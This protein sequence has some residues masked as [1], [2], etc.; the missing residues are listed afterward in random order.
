MR[1]ETKLA[2]WAQEKPE[3]NEGESVVKLK[4][5]KLIAWI[6][7]NDTDKPGVGAVFG[8]QIKQAKKEAAKRGLKLTEGLLIEASEHNAAKKA[9]K[10]LLRKLE[11]AAGDEHKD[12]LPEIRGLQNTAEKFLDATVKLSNK[13]STKI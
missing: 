7:K 2:T 12:S 10:A 5:D 11:Q 4:D 9:I 3:L 13:I 1:F 6:K 8:N